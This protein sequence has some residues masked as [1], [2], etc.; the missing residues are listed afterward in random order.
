MSYAHSNILVI[1]FK[2]RELNQLKKLRRLSLPLSIRECIMN[3]PEVIYVLREFP[4]LRFLI[5][6]W[7]MWC[8]SYDI[9]KVSSGSEN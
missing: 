2:V 6:S 8:E 4:S 7:G 5:L 3:M 1:H 9:S